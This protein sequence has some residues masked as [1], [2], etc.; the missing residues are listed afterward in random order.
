L[1]GSEANIW[2]RIG[3]F[4]VKADQV[5]NLRN[6]YND[7]AVPKVRAFPGNRGCMLLEPTSADEL[8]VV[9]TIWENRSAAEAFEASG[10][11]AEVVSLVRGF[12]AGPPTL[13]SYESA[14]IEGLPKPL[15]G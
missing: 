10:A 11:A 4:P 12:F 1:S 5:V 13:R 2:V 14:S 6:A 8:F 9:I 15:A 3:S 7:L